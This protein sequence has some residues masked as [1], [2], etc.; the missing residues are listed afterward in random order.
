MNQVEQHRFSLP[1]C[2]FS[3]LNADCSIHRNPQ[4]PDQGYDCI[5]GSYSILIRQNR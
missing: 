5:L 2:Y 1:S 3:S 4:I